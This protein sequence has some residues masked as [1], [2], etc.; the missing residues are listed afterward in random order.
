MLKWTSA[1]FVIRIDT[2]RVLG[3]SF[4]GYNSKAGDLTVLRLKPTNGNTIATVGNLKL[5]YALH[6][7]SIT[8]IM[9]SGVSLLK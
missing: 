9:D 2:E 6:Y 1:H 4:S 5:H 7:D 8:Q 3:A